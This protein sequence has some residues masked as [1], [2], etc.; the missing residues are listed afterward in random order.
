VEWARS[1]DRDVLVFGHGHILRAVVARWLG[2]DVSFAA[3]FALD[4]TSLSVLGWAY[5]ETA[6]E[7]WN[8]LGHL[9]GL[10]DPDRTDIREQGKPSSAA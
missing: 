10:G 6:I 1:E 4:P 3:R 9:D 7:R 5:G 2:H 8:D